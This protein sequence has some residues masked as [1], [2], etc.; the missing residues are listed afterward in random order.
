[1]IVLYCAEA[2]K[3]QNPD[4]LFLFQK[5]GALWVNFRR[6]TCI[7]PVSVFD[8]KQGYWQKRKQEWKAIGL[9]SDAGRDDNLLKG[10]MK[11]LAEKKGCG[12]TG[13]SIFD[14]VL[15]EILYNWYSHSGGI[16]LDPFAGGSVRG[17]VA[18]MLG[19][20][21]IGID[22]SQRQ[23]DANQMN[24]DQLG[25]CPAWHC[26]DS[27]NMDAYIPDG[28]ADLV[29]SCPPYHNLEKYSNHPLDLS[30]MNYADFCEAYAD[31]IQKAC[32]KLKENRFAVFVVGDIRDNKGA[33]RDF[34]GLTKK[35]FRDNG[36]C[37]Y[38]ESVLLEQYGTAPM[39]AGLMF[40]ASRKTVKVH[41]NVLVFYKG[42]LKKIKEN[43]KDD[44]RKAELERILQ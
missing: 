14:P 36:L 19:R 43:F 22:L 31:I 6:N 12:L 23:V 4:W 44:F 35:L 28:A 7:P 39:R 42:D 2:R 20:H 11:R 33:Y 21:Y 15:C 13:T 16:V 8:T 41:Q 29:F 1:M 27:R 9:Q 40:S 18:E 24:A 25:V 10:G 38:N 26:D 34:I 32:R 17:I 5:G 3:G 30:N 37:L